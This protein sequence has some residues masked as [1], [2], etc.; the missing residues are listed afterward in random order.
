MP[1]K[2][3]SWN[4]WAAGLKLA[5]SADDTKDEGL[6]R[7]RN[8]AY[9]QSG[10]LRMIAPPALLVDPGT[11]GTLHSLT[12]FGS[13]DAIYNIVGTALR[14]NAAAVAGVPTLDGN[15]ATFMKAPPTSGK[16][17]QLFVAG[18]TTPPQ[19]LFKVS[20]NGAAGTATRW[21]IAPPTSAQIT[22][23]GLSKA[24]TRLSKSVDTM[25][26]GWTV[27]SDSGSGSNTVTPDS[28]VAI[29]ADSQRID[30]IRDDSVRITKN[31]TVDLA[32]FAG[33]VA[34]S[35]Q[36]YIQFYVRCR[37]PKHI[38]NVEII[39]GVGGTG[40]NH[41]YSREITFRVVKGKQKK[42]LIGLGD[43]IKQKDQPTFLSEQ[44]G[45]TL[46][47]SETHILGDT[48]I[49]VAKNT[50]TRVTLPKASFE[51]NG[52]AGTPGFTWADV[53]AVRVQVES[54]KQGGGT[55]WV[56]D[57]TLAGGFGMLGNYK[58]TLT[59]LNENTGTRSNPA[60]DNDGQIVFKEIADVDRQ[61]VDITVI[62]I[63][64]S[65]ADTQITH[66]EIW[67]TIGN[68]EVY[69]FDKK[70]TLGTASTT[71]STADYVGLSETATDTLSPEVLPTDNISPRDAAFDF[72]VCAGPLYGRVFWARNEVTPAL[73]PPEI[74]QGRGRL[75]YSP[76]GRAEAVDSFID[77]SPSDEPI[78][79]IIV[80]NDKVYVFTL[81]GMYQVLNTDEPFIS[82]PIDGAPG[83]RR[84]YALAAG[85]EGIYWVAI[86]GVYLFDGTAARNITD[87]ELRPLFRGES[88]LGDFTSAF[89]PDQLFVNKNELIVT[90]TGTFQ[91]IREH[92]SGAWR[93]T[94][95]T[96]TAIG[97]QTL[98][99]RIIAGIGADV[100]NYEPEPFDTS[101]TG[102]TF[103]V[104]TSHKKVHVNARGIIQRLYIDCV[105]PS[106]T[107][108]PL[109]VIDGVE[110]A[111]LTAVGAS[112]SRQIV[113]YSLNVVASRAGIRI[114]GATINNPVEIY[115]IALDVYIPDEADWG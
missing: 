41:T 48:T 61:S 20:D 23:L 38:N 31:I 7:A 19:F 44:R 24:G 69:F 2:R 85:V 87:E 106:E 82:N 14:R 113:E 47:L 62:P 21:G 52:N 107:L 56:D 109:L 74:Q 102:R 15:R 10:M 68:G 45:S 35:E 16:T 39:F 64:N 76:I 73:G 6:R 104:E 101:A 36:D 63:A 99:Q 72:N 96:V 115:D 9:L 5:G 114:D 112:A 3:I 37:R 100:F 97:F 22:A 111:A 88:G 12:S 103:T 50:W 11:A 53:Q 91:L 34:S 17:D 60:L 110:Q 49:P 93:Y 83:L 33:P 29:T 70:V 1:V 40:F 71:D 51:T 46:D 80:W 105:N 81:N 4:D 75:Y 89:T 13:A 65:E 8:V 79:N 54:N 67:R 86:D 30:F 95:Y 84:P 90:S 42:K 25:D 28:A 108:T 77:I 59:F 94:D 78:Q 66:V 26:T 57:I 58:Y 18:A 32:N 55:L 27:G 92:E 43:L 98:A